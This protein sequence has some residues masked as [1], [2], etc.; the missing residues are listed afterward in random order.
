MTL[1]KVTLQLQVQIRVFHTPS[2][3]LSLGVGMPRGIYEHKPFS[4]E[5][6]IKIG[7]ALKGTIHSEETK[8]KMSLARKG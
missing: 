6:K 8:R 5:H 3:L 4:E 7:L 1:Q 2:W